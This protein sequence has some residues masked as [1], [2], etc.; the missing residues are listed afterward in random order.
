MA[1]P[2]PVIFGGVTY[3]PAHPGTTNYGIVDYTTNPPPVGVR[4]YVVVISTNGQLG[5][6]FIDGPGSVS[7]NTPTK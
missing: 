4:P 2:G 7:T 3:Y 1:L 6:R 5:T